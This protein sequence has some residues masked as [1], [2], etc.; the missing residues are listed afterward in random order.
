MFRC[1]RSAVR[2]IRTAPRLECAQRLQERNPPNTQRPLRGAARNN[3]ERFPSPTRRTPRKN[4]TQK[5]HP[6]LWHGGSS[7]SV[8]PLPPRRNCS[9]PDLVAAGVGRALWS[10]LRC[11]DRARESLTLRGASES[12]SQ[13]GPRG[14]PVETLQRSLNGAPEGPQWSPR[15]S[16]VEPQRGRSRSGGLEEPQWRSRGAVHTSVG[17]LFRAFAHASLRVVWFLPIVLLVRVTLR[18]TPLWRIHR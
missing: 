16:S 6:Q 7:A 3:A 18:P 12:L 8:L 15:G 13:R 2:R 9:A 4:A 5:K 1:H 17:L 10:A 14:A 11:R